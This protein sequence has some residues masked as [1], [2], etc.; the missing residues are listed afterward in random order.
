MLLNVYRI[1]TQGLCQS[2]LSTDDHALSLVA[3]ATT[4]RTVQKIYL[5]LFLCSLFAE[6]TTCPQSCSLATAV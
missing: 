6:E 2:R 5:P 3:P 1:Y 4:A